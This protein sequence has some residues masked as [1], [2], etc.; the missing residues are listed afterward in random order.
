MLCR[1]HQEQIQQPFPVSIA[2]PK[3]FEICPF[4]KIIIYPYFEFESWTTSSLNLELLRVWILNYFE[5]ESWTTCTVFKSSKWFSIHYYDIPPVSVS[6]FVSPPKLLKHF[7][8]TNIHCIKTT[9]AECTFRTA[10]FKVKA[11]LRG[12]KVIWQRYI[13]NALVMICLIFYDKVG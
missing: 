11:T 2:L 4:F 1:S 7:K 12:R 6:N 9:S 3:A 10:Y 13:C 8:G 5:F